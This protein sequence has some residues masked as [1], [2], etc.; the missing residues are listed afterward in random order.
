MAGASCGSSSCTFSKDGTLIPTEVA[1]PP[2]YDQ[3]LGSYLCLRTALIS[4][5]AIDLGKVDGYA[6]LIARYVERYGS[7]S[8][9]QIY[10][11]DVRCTSEHME[12]I[13]RR[14]EEEAALPRAAGHTAAVGLGL[15]GG[16]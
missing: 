9:L 6:R 7:S 8:W 14:G 3:W 2:S 5:Q 13:R 11:A 16:V 4:W 10:Q 15:G 1:G 12:R